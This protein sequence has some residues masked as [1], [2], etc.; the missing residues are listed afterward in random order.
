MKAEEMVR[1]QRHE[2]GRGQGMRGG[3]EKEVV[4]KN[5]GA[6]GYS[7]GHVRLAKL[8]RL[9]CMQL[10]SSQAAGGAAAPPRGAARSPELSGHS[11]SIRDH[12]RSLSSR[13]AV[14]S[15]PSVLNHYPGPGQPP[16]LSRLAPHSARLT[17]GPCMHVCS[18]RLG[19]QAQARRH[20]N[21]RDP[22][23][24]PAP[25]RS[26]VMLQTHRE[27]DGEVMRCD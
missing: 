14:P 5:V 10:D 15:P 4:R 13:G 17:C 8:G 12:A 6:A 25:R 26:V 9:Q 7:L 21:V 23:L 2:M 20:V 1:W 3:Q 19:T 24:A 22:A 11:Y 27:V 16:Q 18:P